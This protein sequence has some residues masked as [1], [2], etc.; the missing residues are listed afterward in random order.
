M[1][2][3]RTIGIVGSLV[4]GAAA[5]AG[6]G[7][8][9]GF[10]ASEDPPATNA[11]APSSGAPAA[12]APDATKAAV[13][14]PPSDPEAAVASFT[15]FQRFP[16]NRA[17]TILVDQ[18]PKEVT[19]GGGAT[20]GAPIGDTG[21]GSTAGSTP[22]PAD[23]TLPATPKEP[24]TPAP[25]TYAASLDVD[26]TPQTVKL[27]DAVPATN[28]DFTVQG[29][30]TATVTLKLISGT[31]PGGGTTIDIAVGASMTL[32]NPTTSVTHVIKVNDVKPQL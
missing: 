27:G 15:G 31:L 19:T 25:T 12:A 7:G 1:S 16:K 26:G 21:G 17:G 10:T 20:S 3:S 13:N 8:S 11:P 4:I 32:T 30:S 18:T 24:A 2:R 9:G 5:L 22:A 14:L 29:I 28:P 23:P 6:C